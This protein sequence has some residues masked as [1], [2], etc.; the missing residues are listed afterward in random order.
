MVI[1]V[2]LA[3]MEPRVLVAV[4]VLMC[5]VESWKRRH[6]GIFKKTG[7]VTVTRSKWLIT[8]MIDLKPYNMLVDELS[9]L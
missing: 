2:F 7:E 6:N 8:L 1:F 3:G 9:E 5:M 4:L